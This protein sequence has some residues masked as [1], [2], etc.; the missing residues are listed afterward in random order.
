MFGRPSRCLC[1]LLLL[2]FCI[3]PGGV[4]L[5]SGAVLTASSGERVG[6]AFAGLAAPWVMDRATVSGGQVEAQVCRGDG[7]ECFGLT[8][9]EPLAPCEGLLLPAWCV[10]FDKG[11]PEEMRVAVEARFRVHLLA[12]IWGTPGAVKSDEEAVAGTAG[13]IFIAYLLALATLFIPLILG[14]FAGTSWRRWRGATGS[15]L[16]GVAVLVVPVAV[17]LFLPMEWL[18]IG[19][20]DILLTGLLVAA[21]FLWAGRV[22]GGLR[23][24]RESALLAGGLLVGCLL[25]E[26][27]TRLF[28]GAPP[29]FPSPDSAAF[30]LPAS[31]GFPHSGVTC[32]G[33][34][35]DRHPELVA[36]RTRFPERGVQVLHLGD[37]MLAGDLVSP[38]ERTAYR[39]NDLDPGVSHI[40]GGFAGTGPDQYYLTMRRWLGVAEVDAVVWHLFVFN[41]GEDPMTQP[42]AC[43]GNS[44][45]LEF[46]G[47]EVAI[48]CT[49][50]TEAGFFANR[51]VNSPAPYFLRVATHFSHFA[52]QVC[53]VAGRAARER[54]VA[55]A[56]PEEGQRRVR[57]VVQA[58]KAEL[59][60]LGIPLVIVL[61]P[62]RGLWD[63]AASQMRERESVRVFVE[64][65]CRALDIPCLDGREAFATSVAA[66]GTA[67]YFI[68]EPV[69]DYHFSGAGHRLYAEWLKQVLP[70]VLHISTLR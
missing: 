56:S 46:V 18:S 34:F 40:D 43:C 61:V 37:S 44:P 12:D 2:L 55:E 49:E 48:R 62:Y 7:G 57:A 24:G 8:L 14:L 53:A 51:F 19:F 35:P 11:A 52:R 6:E 65:F 9:S 30:I 5:A 20:Y 38:E 26:A 68:N 66:H 1:C 47:D 60:R 32:D 17:A 70:E 21:G 13:A 67:P 3:I 64:S 10:A 41:D 69:W 39:L 58:A 59:E 36:A 50:P 29:A 23:G 31:G 33:L 22:N 16:A 28:S 15:R 25:A 63:P 4:V 27:G 42:Y 45:P 54:M